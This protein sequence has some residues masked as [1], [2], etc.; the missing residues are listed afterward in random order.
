MTLA[1]EATMPNFVELQKNQLY[2]GLNQDGSKI[3]EERPYRSRQYAKEKH[4]MNPLP[5]EGNPDLFLTGETYEGLKADVGDK[6]ISIMSTDEKFEGLQG[7][8]VKAF[9]GLG[10]LYLAEYQKVLQLV[11]IKRFRNELR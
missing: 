7:Y 1:F 9:A 2:H 4:A 6:A 11:I 10:G 3:G 5:G 8:Y